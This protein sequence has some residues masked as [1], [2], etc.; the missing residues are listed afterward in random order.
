ML[1][2]RKDIRCLRDISISAIGTKTEA[3]LKKMGLL[4]AYVPKKYT[5][6]ALVDGLKRKL[7]RGDRILIPRAETAP[8]VFAELR[9]AG[10]EVDEAP[11]YRTVPGGGNVHLARKLLEDGKIHIL[12]FTSAST[13]TNFVDMIGTEDLGELLKGVAVSCIGP[14]TARTAEDLGLPVHVVAGKHTIEGMVC[15]ILNYISNK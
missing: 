3:E 13:V 6:R 7:K 1:H 10:L 5:S 9:D 4:S 12:T 11:A 15:G 2:L 8:D 14:V